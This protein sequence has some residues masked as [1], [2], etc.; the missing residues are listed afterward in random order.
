MLPVDLSLDCGPCSCGLIWMPSVLS[1]VPPLQLE[2]TPCISQPC[3]SISPSAPQQLLTLG[4]LKE[5]RTVWST[6]QPPPR[7]PG[8]PPHRSLGPSSA[9]TCPMPPS[10]FLSSL[11]A[12]SVQQD[13]VFCLCSSPCATTLKV[14]PGR[15]GESDSL[16]APLR[17]RVTVPHCLPS[18]SS[19][20]LSSFIVSHCM[21]A[22]NSDSVRLEV[23]NLGFNHQATLP[24]CSLSYSQTNL[25]SLFPSGN[26]T[27]ASLQPYFKAWLKS[28]LLHEGF[29]HYARPQHGS[30]LWPPTISC[31]GSSSSTWSYAKKWS[32][33]WLSACLL[34]SKPA[35]AGMS[36]RS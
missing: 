32:N 28:C 6:T 20:I 14:P 12:S 35:S 27:S 1:V 10:P 15:Q 31:P 26:V 36:L 25:P 17:L 29:T 18:S 22:G 23:L 30:I 33:V 5:S 21:L 24:S 16:H 34:G 9:A 7:T 2:L 3:G 4:G 19:R 11:S 13:A 8:Q